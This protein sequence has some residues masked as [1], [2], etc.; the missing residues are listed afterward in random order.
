[1]L[2]TFLTIILCIV[3][4]LAAEQHYMTS[5]VSS[6]TGNEAFLLHKCVML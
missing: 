6:L 3:Y 5:A 2:I 4:T 1:M